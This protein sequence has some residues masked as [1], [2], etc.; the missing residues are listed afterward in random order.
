MRLP[1]QVKLKLRSAP[2]YGARLIQQG[3]VYLITVARKVTVE[4]L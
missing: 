4:R 1:S 2:L 3:E